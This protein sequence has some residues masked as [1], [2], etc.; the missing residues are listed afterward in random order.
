MNPHFIFVNAKRFSYC[1]CKN[2]RLNKTQQPC[3]SHAPI[4]EEDAP[5][6]IWKEMRKNPKWPQAVEQMSQRGKLCPPG[7]EERDAVKLKPKP[8]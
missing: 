8:V 2:K 5:F 4:R 3:F 7:S 6:A 1:F